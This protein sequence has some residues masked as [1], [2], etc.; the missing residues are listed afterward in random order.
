MS[1]CLIRHPRHYSIQDFYR[2][3]WPNIPG[4][5]HTKLNALRKRTYD[6]FHDSTLYFA[7]SKGL[8]TQVRQMA[9][10]VI[11]RNQCAIDHD[12][13]EE[14]EELIGELTDSHVAEGIPTQLIKFTHSDHE[15]WIPGNE[16]KLWVITWEPI[17]AN[18]GKFCLVRTIHCSNQIWKLHYVLQT[19]PYREGMPLLQR[20]V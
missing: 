1:T 9:F 10:K 15:E 7:I 11:S 19:L 8:E 3:R 12:G 17:D 4:H 5:I 18:E 2:Y 6:V 20:K 16:I 14:E 13:D